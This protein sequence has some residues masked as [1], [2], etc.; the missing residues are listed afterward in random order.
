MHSH[1]TVWAVKQKIAS[2]LRVSADQLM[3]VIGDRPSPPGEYA[4]VYFKDG[5]SMISSF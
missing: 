4:R 1:E 3:L 5:V 2:Y